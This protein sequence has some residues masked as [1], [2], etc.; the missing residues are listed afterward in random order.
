MLT[1]DSSTALI[2]QFQGSSQAIDSYDIDPAHGLYAQNNDFILGLGESVQV[3]TR[4]GVAQ[5]GQIPSSDGAIQSLAS[6]FFSYQG[7][8]DTLVAMYS[9]VNGVRFYDQLENLFSEIVI[10]V[11]GAACATFVTDGL[12]IYVAFSDFSGRKGIS[13]GYVFGLANG[14]IVPGD[15]AVDTLFASPLPTS[16]ATVAVSQPGSGVITAGTHNLGYIFLTRNGDAASK[17]NPVDANGV[18]TPVS[19]TAADGAHNLH[20]VVT[21]SSIPSYLNPVFAPVQ[22]TIQLVMTSASNPA[23]YYLVPGA[24]AIIPPTPGAVPITASISDGDLVTGTNVTLNQNL[25][26]AV[27]GIGPFDPWAIST[28]SSRMLYCTLD[29]AGFPV[30][31]ASDVN[32]YQSLSAATSGIYLEGRQIPVQCTSLAGLCYIATI[33]SLYSTQDN[34]GTPTTWTSPTRVDGSVGI[35]SPT[36][37]LTVGGKILLASEKGLYIY[38]GGAFPQ[39]PISYWQTPDWQRINWAQPT[40]VNIVD[41]SQ[42][43]VLR[44]HAPLKVTVIGASNTS[45]IMITTAIIINGAAVPNPHLFQT[46]LSVTI[47][48]ILGN[49]NANTTQVITVTGP[50]TFTIPVTGNGTY[51]SGGIATPNSP[52]AQMCWNYSAGDSPGQCFY[53]LQAFSSFRASSMALIRN[54][55]T[56]LDEV[57]W[58]G[59]ASAPGGLIRRVTPTFATPYRDVDMAGNPAAINSMY[60][61]SNLPGSQ[62][63]ATTLHDYNGMHF[64]ASGSGSLN[65]TAYSLDHALTVIPAASPFTLNPRPGQEFRMLWFLRSEQQTIAMGTNAIDSFYIL[66]LI[67]AYY[68]NSLPMR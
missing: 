51:V 58:A 18:F 7:A 22:P 46:G 54:V 49:T 16:I 39:I 55:L 6:W 66:A 62:D 11:T 5:L 13:Q 32:D 40:Q 34:G 42:D 67:R 43:K 38:R 56:N 45:P 17:L 33:A 37:M 52:N 35:L 15:E 57:W 68:S 26:S 20:V 48:G 24:I 28:Y 50:N 36:C 1:P 21:F 30:T 25:L 64:R 44:V 4:R 23:E 9:A 14:A 2:T 31:Y 10:P 19:F 60:E 41:D 63:E 47:A 12:R 27:N 3:A 53:S 59:S 29:S 8:Q 65:V 61:T